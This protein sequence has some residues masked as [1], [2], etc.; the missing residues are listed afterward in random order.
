MTAQE[1][2]T[3][4]NNIIAILQEYGDFDQFEVLKDIKIERKNTINK[5]YLDLE[6][7]T[8]QKKKALELFSTL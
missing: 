2:E 5:E 8:K 4:K 3:T 6:E 7:K 1:I